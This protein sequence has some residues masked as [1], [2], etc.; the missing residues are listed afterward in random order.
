MSEVYK[1]FSS[2]VIVWKHFL[3]AENSQTAKCKLCKSIIK[4]TGRST[5][6]LHVHLKPKHKINTKLEDSENSS[7]STDTAITTSEASL[8]SHSTELTSHSLHNTLSTPSKKR[9]I[10]D[11]FPREDKFYRNEDITHGVER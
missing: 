4:T 5:K 10:T 6:G 1:D 7:K 2:S 3:K 8:A 9:K 11:H